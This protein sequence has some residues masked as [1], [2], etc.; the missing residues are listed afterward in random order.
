MTRARPH[1]PSRH[2]GATALLVAV[3][4]LAT[5]ALAGCGALGLPGVAVGTPGS[6]DDSQGGGSDGDPGAES[7]DDGGADD[8]SA[9]PGDF[10]SEVPLYDGEVVAA[11]GIAVEGGGAWNVTI[12]VPDLDAYRDI[13]Q[14]FT[15]AGFEHEEFV[16]TDSIASI[17]FRKPP[18]AAMV[19]VSND[20]DRWIASYQVTQS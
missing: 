14:Q 6:P 1:R 7:G 8:G 5:P 16:M 12:V 13:E 4:L 18:F 15:D 10:P 11:N 3:A 19:I 17:N 9:V 20:G 2:R